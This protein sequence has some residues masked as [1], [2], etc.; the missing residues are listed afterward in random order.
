MHTFLRASIC[1]TPGVIFDATFSLIIGNWVF[2]NTSAG[3][4]KKTMKWL[5]LL[6]NKQSNL[7]ILRSLRVRREHSCEGKLASSSVGYGL[8]QQ[9]LTL[10][11]R[12]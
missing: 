5:L 12:S 10:Y 2:S 9:V 4:R 3:E 7:S 8:S 1:L 11:F 6:S